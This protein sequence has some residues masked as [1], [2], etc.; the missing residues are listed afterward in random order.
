VRDARIGELVRSTGVS[1]SALGY[2][3]NCL[4]PNLQEAAHAV[5]VLDHLPVNE[6]AEGP[7]RPWHAA[8]EQYRDE[9]VAREGETNFAGL[10]RFLA[11]VHRLSAERRLS[12]YCYLAEKAA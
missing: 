3:P 9:L 12:R 11:C 4:S 5:E 10:Q 6:A 2:Y 1:I 7:R 8:R